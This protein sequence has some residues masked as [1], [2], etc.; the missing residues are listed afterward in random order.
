MQTYR[1]AVIGCSRMGGFIDDEVVDDPTVVRPYSHAAV[2]GACTRTELVACSDLRV[3]IMEEF[4]VLFA[5]FPYRKFWTYKLKVIRLM[6][7]L[8]VRI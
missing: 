5:C 2:F 6:S 1:S 8:L 7:G 4:G 3:D